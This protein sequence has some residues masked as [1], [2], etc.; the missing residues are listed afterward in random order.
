M[1][2][3]Q[4]GLDLIKEFEGFR[5][6]AYLC[7]AGVW[8]IGYGHTGDVTPDDSCTMAEAEEMLRKDVE[9]FEA[10]VDRLVKV[11]LTEGQ[12]DALVSFAFNLGEGNLMQSTLLKKLNREDY[13]GAADEFGKWVKAGNKTLPGLVRRREAERALFLS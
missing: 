13:A 9:R 4:R 11:P 8:T 6:E 7:P 12:F 5:A 1:K 3:S 10:A 2:I